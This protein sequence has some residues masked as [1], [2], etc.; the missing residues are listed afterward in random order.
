MNREKYI[1]E[2]EKQNGYCECPQLQGLYDLRKE[3]E[4]LD[5]KCASFKRELGNTEELREDNSGYLKEQQRFIM[6]N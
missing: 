6:N 2:L 5:L 3:V 4:R 1:S